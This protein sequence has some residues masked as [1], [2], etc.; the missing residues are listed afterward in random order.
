MAIVHLLR[1]IFALSTI[2]FTLFWNQSSNRVV[3]RAAELGIFS[4]YPDAKSFLNRATLLSIIG[5]L[6]CLA[7]ESILR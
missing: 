4:S 6:T 5:F 3:S 7:L 2:F 1:I